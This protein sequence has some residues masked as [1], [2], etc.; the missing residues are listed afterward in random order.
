MGIF[1]HVLYF[2]KGIVSGEA[3]DVGYRQSGIVLLLSSKAV[4]SLVRQYARFARSI[5]T[6]HANT[7][8]SASPHPGERNPSMFVG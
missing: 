8:D 5:T 3:A 2:D 6:D 4:V 1:V 7:T